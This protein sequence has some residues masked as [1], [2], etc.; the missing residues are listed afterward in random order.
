MKYEG[1]I[2][3]DGEK[4][5]FQNKKAFDEWLKTNCIK[6]TW[7]DFQAEPEMKASDQQKLYHKWKDIISIELG[8]SPDYTHNYFKKEFNNNKTTKGFEIQ[9]WREFMEKVKAFAGDKSISLPLGKE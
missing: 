9:D 1:R 3:F 6:D 4:S 5:F 7:L 8:W 2:Y